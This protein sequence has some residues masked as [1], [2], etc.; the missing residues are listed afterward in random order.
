[1]GPFKKSAST[2]CS[3]LAASAGPNSSSPASKSS[4]PSPSDAPP[5][6]SVDNALFGKANI[7]VV[8]VGGGGS[9]AV[10]RMIKADMQGIDFWALA[11]SPVAATNKMQIGETLTRGLGAGGKPA[12]G[13]K[14]AQESKAQLEAALAGSDMVFV[15]AGMGGGTGSGAAPVVAAIAKSLGILTVAIAAEAIEALRQS[16]D[17]LIIIPN[18]K[19]LAAVDPNLPVTEAFRVADDGVRGIS[20]IITV[21]GLVNVDFADVRAVMANAGSSLMGQGR[22]SG[23]T[24]ARDAALAAISSPLLDTGIERATGIVWNITGPADL[25]LYEVNEAAE[26][27]YDLVDPGANLI[28]GAVVDPKMTQEGRGTSIQ[29]PDFLRRRAPKNF[30]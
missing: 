17:T 11:S 9:N 16:V 21:P 18:D 22:A 15:T 10:N 3:R 25:T 12:I 27:V 30:N 5:S 19:L 6:N 23:K 26:I 24:R 28:F 8:G 20:D 13:Q 14:A 1:M 4:P 7:K 29:V 2:P